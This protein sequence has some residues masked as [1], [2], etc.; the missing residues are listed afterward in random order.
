MPGR[1]ASA[2]IAERLAVR[3]RKLAHERG[4]RPVLGAANVLRIDV[5]DAP[6]KPKRSPMPLCHASIADRWR[7]FRDGWHRFVAH[8]RD[9]SAAFRAGDLRAIFPDFAFRPWAPPL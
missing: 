1:D 7:A 4:H 8:Y 2:E 3:R 6:T 9:A 5:F